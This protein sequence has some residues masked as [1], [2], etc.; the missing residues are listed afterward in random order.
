MPSLNQPRVLSDGGNSS[1]PPPDAAEQALEEA[2]R[3]L[4][5]LEAGQKPRFG[6]PNEAAQRQTIHDRLTAIEERLAALVPAKI[7]HNQPPEPIESEV[8]ATDAKE[9]RDAS[10][11][12]ARE[13]A[14]TEPNVVE[15]ARRTTILASVA[16]RMRLAGGGA[17]RFGKQVKEKAQ[18]KAAEIVATAVLG[19]GAA[20]YEQIGNALSSI[21][22]WFRMLF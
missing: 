22:T 14:K 4:T 17:A 12:I 16:Q 18:D 11:A 3:V 7:G 2:H 1:E 5:A 21:G 9:V 13:V 20:F 8:S 10:Q 15:V 19:S 6:D